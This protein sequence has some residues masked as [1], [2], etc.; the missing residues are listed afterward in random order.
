MRVW[1]LEGGISA[2]RRV[3]ASVKVEPVR[4]PA[5]GDVISDARSGDRVTAAEGYLGGFDDEKVVVLR[6]DTSCLNAAAGT[7]GMACAE[8]RLALVV[9]DFNR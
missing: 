9:Y 7:M 6:G 8:G 4:I 3:S 5:R 2:R 1:E